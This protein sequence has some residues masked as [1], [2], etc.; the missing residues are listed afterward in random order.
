MRAFRLKSDQYLHFNKPD[1]HKPDMHKPDTQR[2]DSYKTDWNKPASSGAASYR[3]AVVCIALL[4]AG[5]LTACGK[6]KALDY[7]KE[8]NWIAVASASECKKKD[9]DVFFVHCTPVEGDYGAGNQDMSDEDYKSYCRAVT[10]MEQEIFDENAA[11]YAPYYESAYMGVYKLPLEEREP[12]LEKAYD[13][14]SAAF[15]YYLKN[16]NHGRPIILA[17]FSQGGDMV[18]RLLKDKFDDPNLSGKLVAAYVMGWGVGDEDLKEAPHL[19]MATGRYDT[20]VVVNIASKSEELEKSSIIDTKMHGINPLNWKTDGTVA[21]ADENLGACFM[22]FDFERPGIREEI[23]KFCGAYLDGSTGMVNVTGIDPKDYSPGISFFA[24]GEYHIYDYQFFYRNLQTNV[25]E[26]LAEYIKTRALKNQNLGSA[27]YYNLGH[28]SGLPDGKNNPGH[29][30]DLP[31][32]KI[33]NL[34]LAPDTTESMLKADYWTSKCKD[35]D[36]ILLTEKEI[37]DWNKKTH[38]PQ[39]NLSFADFVGEGRKT[40]LSEAEQRVFLTELCTGPDHK[41]LNGKPLSEEYWDSLTAIR[42]DQE[43]DGEVTVKYGVSTERTSLRTVPTRDV[44]SS[45]ETFTFYDEFQNSSCLLNEP[46]IILL[47]ST[48]G[49]WYYV[50]TDYCRGWIAASAVG[51]TDN[52]DAW[53]R[54]TNPEKFIVITENTAQLDVDPVKPELSRHD[55]SMGT[56]LELVSPENFPKSQEGREAY[57]NYVVKMPIRRSNGSLSYQNVY[58]PANISVSVGFLPY[59]QRNLLTLAFDCIGERY[60]WGGMYNARDCSQFVME[61]YRCFG[62]HTP[63]N[64]VGLIGMDTLSLRI[65]DMPDS[66]KENLLDLSPAGSILLF[67]GHAML[68]V[69]SENGIYYVISDTGS[70]VMKDD[71]TKTGVKP[72][73]IILNGLDNYR[74]SGRTWMDSL[75]VIK[76]LCPY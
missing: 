28:L 6:S 40:T 74:A 50:Q 23:P 48:D 9:A 46:L 49:N 21:S 51:T 22:N 16:Y 25:K 13:D 12:Y 60:G 2:T 24:E 66:Y 36:R 10:Y 44:T 32:G 57:D 47:T 71:E 68:Y 45:S 59:T 67:P 3:I 72:Q 29:L 62:I 14:I 58:L 11:F 17:G 64:T 35:P 41:Y 73:S 20:G 15:D 26:R 30:S 37:A 43:V 70:I 5:L 8:S 54:N 76:I 38:V 56:R 34:R 63:R 18:T 42:G 69:G 39:A 53:Y 7:S 61:L 4:T 19:Q 33:E 75:T 65:A 31:D 1:M 52:Y 27:S 55:L